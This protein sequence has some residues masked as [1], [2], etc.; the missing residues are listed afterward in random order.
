[1]IELICRWLLKKHDKQSTY[2]FCPG[3]GLELC[4]SESWFADVKSDLVK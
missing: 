3:C 1:M 4:N 2:C